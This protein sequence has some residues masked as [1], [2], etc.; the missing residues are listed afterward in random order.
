MSLTSYPPRFPT[1]ALTLQT[2]L[3]QKVKP[4]AVILWIAHEDRGALPP[5]VLELTRQGLTIKFCDNIRSYKKIIPLMQEDREL[6][7]VTADDDVYYGSN[8]LQGLTQAFDASRWEVI[9]YRAHLIRLNQTGVPVEYNKWDFNIDRETVS[10]LVFPT[11]IGGIFY[12][13][14]ILH[15]DVVDQ[16][17]FTQLCPT[18]DDIW[19]YFMAR[20]TGAAWRKIGKRRKFYPWVGTQEVALTEI[21]LHGGENDRQIRN[22]LQLDGFDRVPS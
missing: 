9:C 13:P 11:G 7:I 2:L 16:E 17:R 12:R 21:N 18:T 20:R 3:T 14:G 15:S 19:L 8:W 10:D 1:L 6:F 22:M 4:N 5:Q